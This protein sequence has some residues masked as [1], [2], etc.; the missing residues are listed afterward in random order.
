[1][2]TVCFP[3]TLD[4]FTE[5]CER[6]RHCDR[7]PLNKSA[8]DQPLRPLLG[9]KRVPSRTS[10]GEPLWVWASPAS[11]RGTGSPG[12]CPHGAWPLGSPSPSPQPHAGAPRAGQQDG[13]KPTF[14]DREPRHARGLPVGIHCCAAVHVH[15][16]TCQLVD[17]QR[18]QGPRIRASHPDARPPMPPPPTGRDHVP[19]MDKPRSSSSRSLQPSSGKQTPEQT[20]APGLR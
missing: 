3:T 1:M 9:A 4:L 16:L 5:A 7:S 15:V 12:L 10:A 18:G 14:N 19:K 11:G 2:L 6:W 20:P 8:A 13:G 17:L